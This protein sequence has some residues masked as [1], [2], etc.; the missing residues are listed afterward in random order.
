MASIIVLK[1]SSSRIIAPASLAMC[2]PEPMAIPTS[3]PDSA[4]T[5]LTPSPVMAV[6]LWR[7][8]MVKIRYF[9][10]GIT[11]EK[12]FVRSM[13]LS[14]SSSVIFDISRQSKTSSLSFT[15]PSF[16]PIWYAVSKWSPVIM[17][18]ETPAARADL[19]A[20]A[21]SGRSTSATAASPAN[22]NFWREICWKSA[23]ISE[24]SLV[25]R[26]TTR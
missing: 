6:I 7:L 25:A 9:C 13:I 16:L 2:D 17:R 24:V 21:A 18:T 4:G 22:R 10:S 1:L 14:S 5:S 26:P 3:A 20:R 23:K 19:M 8:R 12:T 11:R 15:M